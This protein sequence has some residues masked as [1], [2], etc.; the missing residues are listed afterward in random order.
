MNKQRARLKLNRETIS[1][2]CLPF[3]EA[4]LEKLKALKAEGKIFEGDDEDDKDDNDEYR[5]LTPI[6]GIVLG[7]LVNQIDFA[8]QYLSLGRKMDAS[9][10]LIDQIVRVSEEFLAIF[11]KEVQ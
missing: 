11:R 5:K 6:A 1:G 8:D 4:L 10:N 2:F 3:A 7:Y 9:A